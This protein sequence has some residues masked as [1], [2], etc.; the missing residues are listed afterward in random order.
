MTA[1]GALQSV[2]AVKA[3]T[4]KAVT[5]HGYGS[6]DVLMLSE[7][8]RP[9]IGDADVLV[10]VR[11]S[12]VNAGDWRRVRAD[13]WIV[14]PIEGLFRPRQTVGGGDVAGVVEAVGK[15]VTRFQPGDEVFGLK[16]PAYAEYTAGPMKSL[17][18]KP[19]NLTFEEA[20]A[21]PVAAITALQ[22]LRDKGGLEAGQ[23]VLITG[24]G[25][26]VGTFAVQ[27]AKALGG[28]VTAATSPANAELVRSLGADEVIDYSDRAA[29]RRLA[30]FD[31]ILDIAANWSLPE[32]NRA[33]SPHGKLVLCGAARG[34]FIAPIRRL[35]M[36]TLRAR[37]G[38]R[39]ISY[40]AKADRDDMLVLKELIEADKLRP[41]IDRTYPLGEIREAMRYVETG[42]VRGKVV[43]TI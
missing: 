40:I 30:P 4:M 12:S 21:V 37:V 32:L 22:G 43:I 34:R 16:S 13:P 38:Q 25:G 36:G 19:E 18:P 26:G 3:S 6:P 42:Q 11:A 1:V 5:Q 10:R 31:V 23:R 9:V 14:R 33:L 20:A 8:D 27:I 17:V 24:A 2:T 41:V 39:I 7:V 28:H 15:D 35:L 29:M